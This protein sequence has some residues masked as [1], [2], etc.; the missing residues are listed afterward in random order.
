MRPDEY[1]NIARL[2]ESHWWYQGLRDAVRQT[3]SHPA[4]TPPPR[5]NVL[6]AG[7]G[8]GANLRLL[9][10][11]LEPTYLGGFD[12]SP[13]ALAHARIKAPDAD[14]YH[15]DICDPEIHV[16]ALD[17]VVS[18]DVVY[19]PGVERA[20]AGLQRLVER[21]R[22]GGCL[23]L[24]LP[25]YDWL[26]SEHDVVIHTSERYTT[27]KIARLFERLGLTTERMSY[28]MFW[29]FPAVVLARLPSI[30]RSG[31]RDAG[32]RSDVQTTAPTVNRLLYGILARENRR[33]ARGGRFP[34]GSSVFAVGRKT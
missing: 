27:P 34:W 14:I 15:G 5:P 20:L 6:D 12:L 17:L 30:I 10:D 18:L 3:L 19:I 1:D 32:E 11:L 9:K 16:D 2:E 8:T 13:A 4:L 7:C 25:A 23:L 31:R 26:F 21:L 24:N 28:R 29:L 33:L 22:P